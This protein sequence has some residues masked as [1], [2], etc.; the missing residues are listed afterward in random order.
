MGLNNVNVQPVSGALGAVVSD[1][2]LAENLGDLAAQLYRRWVFVLL[3]VP[4]LGRQ[5][6]FQHTPRRLGFRI[7]VKVVQLYCPSR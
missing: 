2:D 6:R 7:R 3:L 1:I 4:E 5:D